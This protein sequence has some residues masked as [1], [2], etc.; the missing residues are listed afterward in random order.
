M[1]TPPNQLSQKPSS[2]P[3]YLKWILIGCGALIVVSIGLSLIGTAVWYFMARTPDRASPGARRPLFGSSN[4][5]LV[6]DHGIQTVAKTWSSCNTF[7][8]AD[9]TI[10]GN[11]QRVGI[12]VD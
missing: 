10:T 8:P 5:K 12:G 6:D 3:N 4:V 11:E 9:W 1:A 7:A 2:Q